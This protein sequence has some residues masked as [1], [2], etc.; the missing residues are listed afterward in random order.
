MRPSAE[1]Q[2]CP[3]LKIEESARQVDCVYSVRTDW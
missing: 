3:K 1:A 2:S